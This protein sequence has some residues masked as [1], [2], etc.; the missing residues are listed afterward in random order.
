MFFDIHSHRPARQSGVITIISAD[1]HNK[2]GVSGFY[3]QSLGKHTAGHSEIP[4]YL[5]YYSI[6]L[7]PWYI[8]ES[9]IPEVRKF[10]VLPSVVAIGETGLD[11][12]TAK[13]QDDFSLQKEIFT[14]HILISE[15]VKKPLVIHCVKAWDELLHI[16]KSS[17]P[18]MPWIIH[19]FRGN[20]ILATQLLN[21]GLYL[22][23]GINHNA[24]AL[25]VA[26]DKGRLFAETDDADIGIREICATIACK[27]DISI[28]DLLDEISNLFKFLPL[29]VTNK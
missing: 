8:D 14:E 17:K 25:K 13:N 26:W 5:G 11:K 27:L 22:S 9:L 10:A 23:F 18:S 16:H 3:S 28:N 20:A 7:H 21:A 1:I 15:E 4:S 19:G 6:G 12:N 2:N 24:E 29:P